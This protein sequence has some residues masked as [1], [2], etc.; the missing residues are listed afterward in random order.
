M[1]QQKYMCHSTHISSAFIPWAINST[2]VLL[3]ALVFIMRKQ[4]LKLGI[5]FGDG[6]ILI[7]FLLQRLPTV[8]SCLKQILVLSRVDEKMHYLP[9]GGPFN[10]TV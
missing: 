7:Y 3:R 8:S 4:R 5:H 10:N 2:F 1:V 6:N 9:P